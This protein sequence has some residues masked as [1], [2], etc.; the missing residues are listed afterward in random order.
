M[1][2]RVV[3]HSQPAILGQLGTKCCL[4]SVSYPSHS[5]RRS[6]TQAIICPK[7]FLSRTDTVTVLI[8]RYGHVSRRV[9][10]IFTSAPP[11]PRQHQIM[12]LSIVK[13]WDNDLYLLCKLAVS[14]C[15][16]NVFHRDSICLLIIYYSFDQYWYLFCG[17]LLACAGPGLSFQEVLL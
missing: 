11:G 14:E 17:P 3:G 2:N 6:R 12:M 13:L 10:F 9:L 5:R 16:K 4:L 8:S 1:K 15:N 7:P